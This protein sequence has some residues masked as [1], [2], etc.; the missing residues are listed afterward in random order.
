MEYETWFIFDAWTILF[1]WLAAVLA[2]VILR[3][4]G[5]KK[6]V[7]YKIDPFIFGLAV[8][9]TAFFI[10]GF[11]II[12]NTALYMLSVYLL[13]KNFYSKKGEVLTQ[14]IPDL[15]SKIDEDIKNG[16]LQP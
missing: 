15:I 7:K 10:V 6:D 3:S 12:I 4:D 5:F 13:K 1:A 9:F 11:F 16:K 14:E 2:Y 8:S